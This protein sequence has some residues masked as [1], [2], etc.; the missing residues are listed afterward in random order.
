MAN[1]VP[2]NAIDALRTRAF[3]IACD[4]VANDAVVMIRL[5]VDELVGVVDDEL[6]IAMIAARTTFVIVV[7]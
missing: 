6:S 2:I 4:A 1:W 7:E 3:C 5:V